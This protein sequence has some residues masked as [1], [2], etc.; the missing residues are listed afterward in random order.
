VTCGEDRC[1]VPKCIAT[2]HVSH[3][4]QPARLKCERPDAR[5]P[6][7]KHGPETARRYL[8]YRK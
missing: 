2:A 5:R 3:R 4:A 7:A 6:A 1:L 8:K